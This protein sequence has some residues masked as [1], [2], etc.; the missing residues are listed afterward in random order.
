MKYTTHE[1]IERAQDRLDRDYLHPTHIALAISTEEYEQR[2]AVL[3]ANDA[4]LE[5]H[6]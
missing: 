3:E 5:A 2:C 6:P 1:Q 4:W